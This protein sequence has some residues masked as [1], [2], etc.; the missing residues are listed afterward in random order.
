MV[1]LIIAIENK[2]KPITV[3]IKMD[4]VEIKLVF[5]FNF[6]SLPFGVK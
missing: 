1:E 3:I 4:R 2:P 6:L 5:I